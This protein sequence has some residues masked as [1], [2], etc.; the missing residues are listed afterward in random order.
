MCAHRFAILHRFVHRSV[1]NILKGPLKADAGV[2]TFS[3]GACS[4]ASRVTMGLSAP[5]WIAAP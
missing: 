3:I 4:L 5:A 2:V 1:K